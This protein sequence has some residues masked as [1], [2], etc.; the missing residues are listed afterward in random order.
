M[1]YV[2]EGNQG[3]EREREREREKERGDPREREAAHT[4][5][6]VNFGTVKILTFTISSAI[7]SIFII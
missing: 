6:I 4:R 1:G 2:K 7:L 3:Q 5:K